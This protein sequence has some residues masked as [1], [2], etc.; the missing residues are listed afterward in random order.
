[1]SVFPGSNVAHRS[2]ASSALSESPARAHTRLEA[3]GRRRQAS[4]TPRRPAPTPPLRQQAGRDA[5]RSAPAVRH[6]PVGSGT[7]A[8]ARSS[9]A[10]LLV[11]RRFEGLAAGREPPLGRAL[12]RIRSVAP[13]TPAA[14]PRHRGSARAGRR[15]AESVTCSE[16]HHESAAERSLPQRPSPARTFL[17]AGAC[18]RR[19]TR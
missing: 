4:A 3:P 17:P 13:A 16:Q 2:N 12:T 5:G 8:S 7:R 9:A 6:R 14:A 15:A 11:S 19:S 18:R 10:A 1:M